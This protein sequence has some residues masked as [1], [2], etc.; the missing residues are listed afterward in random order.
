MRDPLWGPEKARTAQ[1][2]PGAFS[3]WMAAR[4]AKSFAGYDDLHRTS[5]AAPAEFQAAPSDFASVLGDKG[6]PPFLFDE[7]KMPGTRFFPSAH[8]NFAEN[9]LRKYGARPPCCSGA[10]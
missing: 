1:T 7:S 9:L 6:N 5:V 3:G 4:T 10:R 8:L 2:I